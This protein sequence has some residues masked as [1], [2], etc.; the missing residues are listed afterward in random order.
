MKS[1][2]D[3]VIH[4]NELA[5]ELRAACLSVE[6]FTDKSFRIFN[7]NGGDTPELIYDS[8]LKD[9]GID[10]NDLPYRQIQRLA[11]EI[12]E[13]SSVRNISPSEL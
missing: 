9:E 2:Q 11:E 10:I 13:D 5:Q 1:T 6:V 7:H 4:L 12:K 3:L 8:D